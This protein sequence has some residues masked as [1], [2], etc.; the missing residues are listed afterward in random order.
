VNMGLQEDYEIFDLVSAVENSEG[1]FADY[2]RL[3]VL[4]THADAFFYA[5]W[6]YIVSL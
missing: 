6:N 1:A 4:A 3:Y 5:I 2:A